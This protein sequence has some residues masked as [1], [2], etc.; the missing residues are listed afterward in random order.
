[1]ASRRLSDSDEDL[2]GKYGALFF[3]LVGAVF[4]LGPAIVWAVVGWRSGWGI[5][6]VAMGALGLLIACAATLF[7]SK[8]DQVPSTARYMVRLIGLL[9]GLLMLGV[10][11]WRLLNG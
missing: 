9:V 2:F 10:S 1:M 6:I 3:G 11:V 8:P 7:D 4:L 5:S